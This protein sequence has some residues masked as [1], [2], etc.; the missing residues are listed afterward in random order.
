[1]PKYFCHI[2]ILLLLPLCAVSQEYFFKQINVDAGLSHNL[3]FCTMQDN[4]GFM[5]FGTK[6][7]L[8][9]YDGDKIKIYR[10]APDTRFNIGN[11][12]I[13]ALLSKSKD[14]IWVATSKGLF[15][16][17]VLS[18]KFHE[19]EKFKNSFV[20]GLLKDGS[21]VWV[22]SNHDLFKLSPNDTSK[23]DLPGGIISAICKL[24]NGQTWIGTTNGKIGYY[25]LKDN[26]FEL[27]DV[28]DTNYRDTRWIEKLHEGYNSELLIGTASA[29]LKSY[30]LKN[31]DIQNILLYD[32]YA[33]SVYV[34][35]IL[36][37]ANTNE[38][39]VATESGIYIYSSENK[40]KSHITK[41]LKNSGGLPDNSIY[42]LA[43][44][45]DE[46]VW[47]GTYFKGVS[48]FP[49]QQMLFKKTFDNMHFG[50]INDELLFK[51]SIIREICN[52]K[53]DN[54]WI[55]TE[56][57]G[58]YKI[59]K[60]RKQIVHLTSSA[61]PGALSYHNIHGML[62]SGDTLWVGTFERGL[63]LINI[64]TGRIIKHFDK[65]SNK[66]L[67]SNFIITFCKTKD[68][69]LYVGTGW[70]LQVYNQ[71]QRSFSTVPG[72][73]TD[74]IYALFESADGH[75]YIGTENNGVI[76]YDPSSKKTTSL[77]EL[78]KSSARLP[79]F[80]INCLFED[81]QRN[82]LIGTDGAGLFIYNRQTAQLDHRNT[83]D[84]YP[85]NFIY[86]IVQDSHNNIWCTT[87]SGLVQLQENYNILKVYTK[88]QGLPSNQ[89][90]Y[91]SGLLDHDGH[92]YLGSTNGMVYFSP[93]ATADTLKPRQI[94][95]Y[96]TGLKILGKEVTTFDESSP[97]KKPLLN[98][99]R[100]VLSYN[101][102]TFSIDF[103]ALV[104]S[105]PNNIVYSYR[106]AGTD[107]RW[108]PL[109]EGKTI[110]FT[111]LP[112][113]NYN[114]QIRASDL[115]NENYSEPVKTLN[116]II[117]PPFWKSQWAYLSYSLIL[118]VSIYLFTRYYYNYQKKINER[119]MEE[120]EHKRQSEINQAKIDFFTNIAHE[121][122]TPLTLIQGPVEDLLERTPKEH[123]DNYELKL[124]E[125]NTNHLLELTNQLL[126]FR[127]IESTNIHI[128][129][130]S[131]NVA[132]LVGEVFDRF[133]IAAKNKNL[134]YRLIINSE[135]ESLKIFSDKDLFTKIMY[136]LFSNGI[137][138]S[139]NSFEVT[140]YKQ[141][142]SDYVTLEFVNDGELIPEDSFSK[143]FQPFYRF[144]KNEIKEGTGIGLS[145]AYSLTKALNGSLS[146]N[147]IEHNNI[148]I[149][150]IPKS[151]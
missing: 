124:I 149:L 26:S 139:K 43:M 116:I 51:N 66:D 59:D 151:D 67:A 143:I 141:S 90:N 88:E 132:E 30:N 38:I 55:G 83:S 21:N 40:L 93:A 128:N 48:M 78:L 72:T 100:L 99:D 106:L 70:G 17:D 50:S 91:N 108:I 3:V 5:W 8:N 102:S 150:N 49:N 15:V 110:Y 86:R 23:I 36:K 122:K 140:L 135:D 7:G 75:L 77:N 6:D 146:V 97:L 54:L 96:F 85:S 37:K 69:T 31:K 126:D 1:M 32:N 13:R 79:Y 41:D 133:K 73:P 57:N 130:S 118:L 147:V 127:K 34:R 101:Q 105:S 148:F 61:L 12:D 109:K 87:A 46:N 52:D 89:F 114:L 76:I 74:F 63:D 29:G 113:G 84:G 107:D 53:D 45:S 65:K 42:S 129:S 125:K 138:Y 39:W 2:L 20:S 44:D 10:N 123:N 35:D 82:I 16:L 145:F 62:C 60:N 117:L 81:E 111:Q 28:F 137:K 9:R 22:I 103:S 142:K 19:I 18:E 120:H 71:K 27:T 121:I 95:L 104:Y 92:I 115:Y 112:H 58:I 94:P 134:H 4:Y 33:K 56:D 131:I 47:A 144:S 25:N 98:S 11:N 64:R 119:K 80:K 136:N 68:H 24:S 14:E